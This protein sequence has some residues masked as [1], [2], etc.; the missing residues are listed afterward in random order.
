[1]LQQRGWDMFSQCT[2]SFADCRTHNSHW[3]GMG[4]VHRMEVLH[5]KTIIAATTWHVKRLFRF[6]TQADRLP[7]TPLYTHIINEQHRICQVRGGCIQ[8]NRIK[9]GYCSQ[10]SCVCLHEEQCL[11][12][13]S[14]KHVRYVHKLA[15]ESNKHSTV[16]SFLSPSLKSDWAIL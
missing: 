9:N 12:L 14:L 7:A 13:S 15:L 16:K 11:L 6:T 10:G 3:R 4:S 5:R 1:M 8:G 2:K